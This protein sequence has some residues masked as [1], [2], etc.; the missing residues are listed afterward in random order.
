MF[1][2]AS[3]T[4]RNAQTA[5]AVAG[6]VASVIRGQAYQMNNIDWSVDRHASEKFVCE[7]A[8]HLDSEGVV[9]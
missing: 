1:T 5:Q 8:V 3:I 9:S 4:T 7:N 2:Q 6:T